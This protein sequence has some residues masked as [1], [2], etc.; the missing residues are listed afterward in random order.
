M[1]HVY[2]NL[3]RQSIHPPRAA[4]FYYCTIHRVLH[5]ILRTKATRTRHRSRDRHHNRPRHHTVPE[6]PADGE[7]AWLFFSPK[8]AAQYRAHDRPGPLS[9]NDSSDTLAISL[10][11]LN[12]ANGDSDSRPSDGA[13]RPERA[14]GCCPAVHDGGDTIMLDTERAAAADDDADIVRVPMYHPEGALSFIP[15]DN[16][17]VVDIDW[18]TSPRFTGIALFRYTD[19]F[20]RAAVQPSGEWDR[21]RRYLRPLDKDESRCDPLLRQVRVW[22]CWA[23]GFQFLEFELR[24]VL[25]LVYDFVNVM[26]ARQRAGGYGY[27]S[28]LL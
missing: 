12:L 5:C 7:C 20:G 28:A 15:Y 21:L 25:T 3:L 18:G 22:C 9:R 24:W 16:P 19:V 8:E 4:E 11:Q 14:R 26:I 17:A 2:P 6:R 13:E 27:E 23:Q 1:D 10:G